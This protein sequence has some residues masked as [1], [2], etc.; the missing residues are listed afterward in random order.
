MLKFQAVAE[1]TAK[2]FS[3]LLFAAPCRWIFCPRKFFC[4][5][6]IYPEREFCPENYVQEIM[7][8]GILP[9]VIFFEKFRQIRL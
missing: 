9:S 2:N 3:R 4:H 1:K 7:S 5:F 6:Y 8:R